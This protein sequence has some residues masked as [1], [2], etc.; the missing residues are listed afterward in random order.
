M[1]K[2]LSRITVAS[3]L[4]AAGVGAMTV[5]ALAAPIV[6]LVGEKTLVMFDS[7][8]LA[9]TGTMD[10]AGVETLIG[11]DVRPADGKLYGVSSD[12]RIVT[13]E[14]STG[15][16]TDVS[17]LNETLAEGL[18]GMVDFNPVADRLRIMG[19][20]GTNLR[21]NPADGM[22]TVDG[23]LKFDPA[24]P[25]ASATPSVVATAYTNSYGKPEATRMYDID[26]AMGLLQQT[27]PNDG[28]LAVIGSLGISGADTYAF[29][30]ST[31]ASGE[32][33]AWLVAG[34]V[35]HTVDLDTGA[36]TVVGAL[37]GVQGD[38]RDIA[39]LPAM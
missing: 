10:V 33:T 14:T 27:A 24:G 16:S 32:N 17:T 21:A 30:I 12:G 35:L 31:T 22:V 26:T 1:S 13:I 28:T 4:A 20:D 5:A 15:A 8:S 19:S 9:A 6:G 37:T 34:G 11:I 29:D 7:E 25:N 39:V 36:A 2:R 18:T 38:I 23:S 3:L